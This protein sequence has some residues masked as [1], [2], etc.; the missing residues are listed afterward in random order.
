MFQVLNLQIFLGEKKSQYSWATKNFN[1]KNIARID[2]LISHFWPSH[3]H[4]SK[5][6]LSFLDQQS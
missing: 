6:F 5:L 4:K 3:K 1:E 2:I